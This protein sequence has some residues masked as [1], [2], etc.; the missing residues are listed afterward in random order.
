MKVDILF[1]YFFIKSFRDSLTPEASEMKIVKF[2]N[3]ID[4][5]E[6]AENE[7]PHPDLHCMS[8]SL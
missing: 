4:L 3:S 2:A 5:D 6:A 7:L 1:L 8:S